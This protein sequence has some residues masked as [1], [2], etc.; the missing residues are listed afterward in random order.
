MNESGNKIFFLLELI[1]S[2]FIII[3]L[4]LV[5]FLYLSYGIK[6]LV[7]CPQTSS[8]FKPQQTHFWIPQ[9]KSFPIHQQSFVIYAL[10][11]VRLFLQHSF[12][13]G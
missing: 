12:V 8:Q 4:S 7:R 13:D 9:I 6:L 10:I 5:I 3:T 1:N 11:Q 2:Q